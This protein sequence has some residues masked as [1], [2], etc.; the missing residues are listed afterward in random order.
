VL[1]SSLERDRGASTRLHAAHELRACTQAASGCHTFGPDAH[2]SLVQIGSPISRQ[3]NGEVGSGPADE[4]KASPTSA[5]EP[6]WSGVDFAPP[7][8]SYGRRE[9]TSMGRPVVHWE[10]M[11]KDPATVS[12]FYANIFGWKIQHLP[13]MNYRVVETGGEGGINGGIVKPE[14]EGPWPGNMLF[15]IDVDDLAAYRKRIV[16]AGGTIHVEEQ[17]VP[18]MGSFSLFTDPEGRMMGLWKQAQQQ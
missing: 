16:A 13:E 4:V 2:P 14:R 12:D 7:Y 1:S 15:Y 10:L 6:F 18:G 5:P 9:E 8:S 3:T 17:H 11:S